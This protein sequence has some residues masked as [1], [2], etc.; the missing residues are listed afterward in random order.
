MVAQIWLV[1]K[2]DGENPATGLING[3]KGCFINLDSAQTAAQVRASAA[4]KF[5]LPAGYFDAAQ[6]AIAAGGLD[7]D[8]D[9]IAFNRGAPSN[10]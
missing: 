4:T 5:G 9:A 8:T 7:V 1:T 2:T 3:I 10:F 6:S